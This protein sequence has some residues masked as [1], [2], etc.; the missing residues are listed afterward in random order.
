MGVGNDDHVV[1]YDDSDTLS[2][3]RA[4]WTFKAFN[5][6]RVSVMHGGW[7]KWTQ[8]SRWAESGPVNIQASTGY[9]AELI[10]ELVRNYEQVCRVLSSGGVEQIVDA[11][12]AGRFQGVAPE[13]RPGLASGHMPGSI[14]LPFT[15]LMDPAHNG[16]MF[17]EEEKLIKV[18]S[19]RGIDLTRPII[20]SCGT[21]FATRET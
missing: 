9:R 21:T 5:H 17:L 7:W 6:N 10:E 4:W 2:S 15:V 12:P 8:E 11:R 14:S 20:C 3:Y 19:S 18:F 16:K 13:P 1:L